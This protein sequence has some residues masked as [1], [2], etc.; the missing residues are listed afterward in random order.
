M[1]EPNNKFQ[2][3]QPDLGA[4]PNLGPFPA[5]QPFFGDPIFTH[6]W[7]ELELAGTTSLPG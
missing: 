1:Q 3:S 4:Q 6:L 7:F 5:S 2:S